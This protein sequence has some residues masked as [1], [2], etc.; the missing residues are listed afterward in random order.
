[1]IIALTAVLLTSNRKEGEGIG[2][3]YVGGTGLEPVTSCV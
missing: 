3:S 2:L 1:M